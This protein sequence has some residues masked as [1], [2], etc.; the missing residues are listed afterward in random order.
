MLYLADTPE[1]AAMEIGTPGKL[2]HVAELRLVAHIRVLDLVDL[3]ESEAGYEL[4]QA[5][6]SS[7]LLAAPRSGSGW[8]KRQYVFSRFVADCARSAGF[9]AIRYGSTKGVAGANIVCLTPPSDISS[10]ARFVKVQD[11]D[12]LPAAVRY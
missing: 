4:M 12:G 2:C 1:V 9:E 10:L 3:D 8:L 7:A 11:M 6:A 5:L